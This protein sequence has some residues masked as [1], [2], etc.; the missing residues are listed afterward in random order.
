MSWHR[1][2][3]ERIATYIPPIGLCVCLLNP[4]L[5]L[6]NGSVNTVSQQ[7]I[8][9]TINELLDASFSIEYMSYQIWAFGSVCVSL[10]LIYIPP[11]CW[12][13]GCQS[14]QRVKYGH[15]SRGT[16]NEESPCWR[17][18][19]IYWT[20]LCTPL[21]L[22]GNGSVNIFQ[23][24]RRIVGNVV[25]CD[26]RVV[27]K[28]R[29]GGRSGYWLWVLLCLCE[30]LDCHRSLISSLVSLVSSEILVRMW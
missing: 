8:Y 4:L 7:R 24:Q 20:G 6:G 26:V 5:V 16:R 1:S 30:V 2:P 11:R 14:R 25:S 18:A 28:E 29:I 9:A 23:R 19:A 22:A 15:E 21:L 17:R 10:I 3:S 13:E 12:S 27:W